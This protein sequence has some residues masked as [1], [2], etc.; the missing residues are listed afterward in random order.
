MRIFFIM[1]MMKHQNRLP[2]GVMDAP[3]L[4]TF[5]V[6]RGDVLNNLIYLKMSLLT[7]G[8]LD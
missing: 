7:A 8:L 2:K 3:S 1:R 6:R 5:E 4:E